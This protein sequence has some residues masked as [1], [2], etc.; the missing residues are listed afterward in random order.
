MIFTYFDRFRKGYF[1]TFKYLVFPLIC[2]ILMRNIYEW[3]IMEGVLHVQ[4]M[5]QSKYSTI[6]YELMQENRSTITLGTVYV[7]IMHSYWL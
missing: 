3:R 2:N 7:K 6:L 5:T 4:Q 1:I